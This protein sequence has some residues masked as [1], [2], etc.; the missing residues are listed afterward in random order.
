MPNSDL[1]LLVAGSASFQ[2]GLSEPGFQKLDW[3]V[4]VIALLKPG[5][6][7]SQ[8]GKFLITS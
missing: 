6:M 3:V 5:S 8:E 4:T 2:L 7:D 1:Q